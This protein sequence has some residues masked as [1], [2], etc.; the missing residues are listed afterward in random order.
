MSTV[1]P[2]KYGFA[3]YDKVTERFYSFAEMSEQGIVLLLTEDITTA[4][5]FESSEAAVKRQQ[6]LVL[7]T[8]RNSIEAEHSLAKG[9]IPVS[10]KESRSKSHNLEI[11]KDT[12]YVLY[13]PNDPGSYLSSFEHENVGTPFEPIS[14]YY[15]MM[16]YDISRPM[17]FDSSA[18]ALR[19]KQSCL[20]TMERHPGPNEITDLKLMRRLEV[21]R[22]RITYEREPV[23]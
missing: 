21:M 3:L 18:G 6:E 10:V 15:P 2:R 23:K 22:L 14:V 20:T 1:G 12:W 19:Y 11:I 7:S 9:L 17:K 4:R 13:D 16:C 5:W 8:M